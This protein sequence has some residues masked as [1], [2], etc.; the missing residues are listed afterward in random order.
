M[1]NRSSNLCPHQPIPLE[2][3]LSGWSRRW[4]RTLL[5]VIFS[6]ER[7]IVVTRRETSIHRPPLTDLFPSF[8]KLSRCHSWG[9]S[10]LTRTGLLSLPNLQTRSGKIPTH[11]RKTSN[12]LS[13]MS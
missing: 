11:C 6:I 9:N 12:G 13:L 4:T 10:P 5:T 3:A 7:L 2:R 8:G 1:I